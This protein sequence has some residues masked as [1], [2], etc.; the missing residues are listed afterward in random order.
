M[1]IILKLFIKQRA[2]K[3]ERPVTQEMMSQ[4][5][6]EEAEAINANNKKRNEAS[7]QAGGSEAV[8]DDDDYDNL[9]S[10]L[11]FEFL[12]CNKTINEYHIIFLDCRVGSILLK[13][14]NSKN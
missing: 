8:E 7:S 13:N 12:Y 5:A 2:Y 4:I 14:S 11:H 1:H 6:D 10:M 9:V 3:N